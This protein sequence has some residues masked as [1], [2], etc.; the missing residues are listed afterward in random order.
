MKLLLIVNIDWFLYSHRLPIVLEAKKKGYEVHIATKITDIS[1]RNSLL[2][3]GI[4]IHELSFDRSGKSL[5]KLI[6]VFFEIILLL[7]KLKP[8]ILHLVTIQPILLGGIAARFVGINKIVYAIS[9]LGHTFLSHNLKLAIRRQI[10]LKIYR[11]A[12]NTKRRIVIFQNPTDQS[13]LSKE[14]SL[15]ESETIIIPGSGLDL[16][17]FNYSKIPIGKPNVLMASRLLKSKGVYE[18]INAAK[19]LKRKGL[20]INFQLVGKPDKSN[21]LSISKSEIHKWVSEGFIEYLGF[22]DDLHKIIPKSHIVVLPSYYPE[23]LPK[24]LCEAAAC[25]RPVITTDKPGC[26]DAIENGITGILIQPKDALDLS[27]AILNIIQ[28]KYLLN[29]MSIAARSRAEKL[30]NIKDVIDQHLDIYASRFE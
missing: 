15:S 3:K 18:F 22:R 21:P 28:N 25:G 14:C 6:T 17:K 23:G 1:K 30:F 20:E 29:K 10:I 2:K 12:L 13:L 26:R 8:N 16:K 11:F 7:Y 5:K 27:N 9:G 19:I 24:I 4:L